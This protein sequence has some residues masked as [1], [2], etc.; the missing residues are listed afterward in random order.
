MGM[1]GM[2]GGGPGLGGGFG[3]PFPRPPHGP[4]LHSGK[5]RGPAEEEDIDALLHKKSFKEQQ[6]SKTAEELL[7]LLHRPTAKETAN[8]AKVSVLSKHSG[9]GLI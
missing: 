3:G 6:Q 7:E 4:G 8:A 9:M 2:P 5:G 1:L